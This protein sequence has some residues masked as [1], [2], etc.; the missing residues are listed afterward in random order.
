MIRTTTLKIPP[1]ALATADIERP[2]GFAAPC[3]RI[4]IKSRR[5]REGSPGA[6]IRIAVIEPP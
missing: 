1:M 3:E 4:T 5:G 2:P 6:L